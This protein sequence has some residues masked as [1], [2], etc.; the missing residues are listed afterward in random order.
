MDIINFVCDII[1]SPWLW[2][3][4]P[5]LLG[6]VWVPKTAADDV[7]CSHINDLQT[8]KVDTDYSMPYK[9]RAFLAADQLNIV[10]STLT[11]VE[12]ADESYDP[13]ADFN[14]GTYSYVCPVTGYYLIKGQITY[15]N[16]VADKRYFAYIR[17]AAASRGAH[18][19]HAAAAETLSVTVSDIILCNA[20]QEIQL[21]AYHI[22]GVDTVDIDGDA[23]GWFTHLYVHLLS[24]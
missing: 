21:G 2:L 7:L 10:D 16:L 5:L 15:K 3:A 8:K 4:A 12:L 19:I 24:I 14:V 17:I 13:S 6:W 23:N 9:A 11:I 18:L 20:G 22:A 1:S